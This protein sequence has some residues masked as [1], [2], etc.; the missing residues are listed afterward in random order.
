MSND[1]RAELD[2]HF[3]WF[4]AKLPARPAQFVSWL[5]KP[6]SKPVRVPLAVLLI[7]G[8]VLSFLP[9]LG[10]WML[11]LG[12][13]LIAQDIPALEKPTAQSLG[14]IERKWHARQQAKKVAAAPAVVE[15]ARSDN[16][17]APRSLHID[18]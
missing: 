2:R 9:V 12:L 4:E 7:G 15:H 10:V 8:G 11:P 1:H 3:T 6:S 18:S 16:A 17:A 5:R 13:I 14:W